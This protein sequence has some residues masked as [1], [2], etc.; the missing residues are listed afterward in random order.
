MR[1]IFP[2]LRVSGWILLVLVVAATLATGYVML[3][4][5][6]RS[7]IFSVQTGVRTW[8]RE[9]LTDTEI[10]DLPLPGGEHVR[11]WYWQHDNSDA[12]TV[13]YLHGARWNLNGSAFRFE[14]LTRLGFSV[15]AID[16]R[17]FGESSARLT[18][19]RSAREDAWLAMQE[20]AR[21]QPRA[22]RRFIYGH[23]LGGAIAADLAT[24]KDVPDF[25]GLIL[26]STFTSIGDMIG[27]QEWG[28]IPGLRWLVTQPFDSRAR[29][30]KLTRPLLLFHGTGDRTV[31][32]E[33]SDALYASASNVPRPPSKVIKIEGASHSGSG[34]AGASYA[35]PVRQFV[36]AAA[37]M[38]ARQQTASQ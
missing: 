29:L 7:M 24:R 2:S 36:Q 18:S 22:E 20:L 5:W 25:A 23:S 9:P 38:M 28:D 19:E 15:L 31:P 30:G 14:Q 17:G 13:L 1:R 34:R 8:W 35:D 26:E 12:P 37:T 21:R 3:D 16:Y 4:R 6:Q 10:L 33:M 32:H 11:A 27:L